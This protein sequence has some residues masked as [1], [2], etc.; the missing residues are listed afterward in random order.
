MKSRFIKQLYLNFVLPQFLI[1]LVIWFIVVWETGIG[2][3]SI[4]AMLLSLLVIYISV[5]AVFHINN[6]RDTLIKIENGSLLIGDVKGKGIIA[7]LNIT[8]TSIFQRIRK[9]E[10]Q[11]QHE[12]LRRLRS[13]IDGQDQERNRLA[14]ELHDGIGQSLI[15]VKLQLENAETQN[16]SMMRAGIDS[17]KS[18]IDHTIE[19]VR[20]VCNALLPAALNEFGIVSTLRALCSEMGSLA[21]FKLVFES[22]GS[23]DRISKKSQVYLYRIAQEALN[24]IAKH[25]RATQVIM[26]LR[27]ENNIVT[28][29][30]SDNGKGF[31]FDPVSFAQRNG[32]QNMRERTHLLQGEMHSDWERFIDKMIESD[33]TGKKIALFGL[34]DQKLYPESFVDGMGTIFCRL[35]FKENVVGYTS[36][37]GYNFYYSTA[38]KDEKFIGLAIDDDTQAELTGKRINDWVKQIRK[39]G[40]L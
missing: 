6:L 39:E 18:R 22:E 10:D 32:L 23:L 25:A 7:Q 14:R 1:L 40:K 37:R 11:L 5:R 17:A 2:I 9:Q 12:K 35:P 26:K 33:L 3:L 36:V 29:E 19:D 21:G 20:R 31:T 15:A 27:R 13:V 38:Q 24:N 8:L 30:V 16:Y 34:G 28:L 4:I